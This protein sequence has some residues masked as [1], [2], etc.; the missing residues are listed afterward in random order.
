MLNKHIDSF[1]PLLSVFFWTTLHVFYLNWVQFLFP[2]EEHVVEREK[3][4]MNPGGK[5]RLNFTSNEK[6]TEKKSK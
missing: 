6:P 2:T 1:F 5:F 4:E 3:N